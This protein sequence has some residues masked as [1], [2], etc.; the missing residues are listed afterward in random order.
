[1]TKKFSKKMIQAWR[2]TVQ[3]YEKL[4]ETGDTSEWKSYGTI[5]RLCKVARV[6]ADVIGTYNDSCCFCILG[7][8]TKRNP[9]RCYARPLE[10]TYDEMSELATEES[11]WN[12]PG[13][14]IKFVKLAKT[15][16]KQL[17]KY[18]DPKLKAAGQYREAYKK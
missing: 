14:E 18:V 4:I 5:C 3:A 9:A 8:A 10:Y 17:R 6:D 2:E 12:D 1:M 16:L 13:W 11:N 15:R 7:D